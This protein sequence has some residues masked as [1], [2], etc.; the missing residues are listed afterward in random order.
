MATPFSIQAAADDMAGRPPIPAGVVDWPVP[1]AQ[2]ERNERVE[3]ALF[4]VVMVALLAAWS[5]AF[6]DVAATIAASYSSEATV[7]ARAAAAPRS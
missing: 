6:I 7:Q 4:G 1:E 5:Y 2:R 3:S